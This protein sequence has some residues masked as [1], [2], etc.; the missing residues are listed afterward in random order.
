MFNSFNNYKY[1]D[2]LQKIVTI[3][4]DKIKCDSNLKSS[5]PSIYCAGDVC[6]YPNIYT[7]QRVKNTYILAYLLI[8]N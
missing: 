3:E 4:D 1:Q 6:S 5:D 2:A 7:G 8:K